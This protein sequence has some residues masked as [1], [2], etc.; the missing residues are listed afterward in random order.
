[1]PVD[2]VVLDTNVW[3]HLFGMKAR[4]T[5]DVARW[6]A[7]LTGKTVAIAAQTRAELLAW[8]LINNIGE[9]RASRIRVHLDL[10]ATIPVDE[11]VIQRFARLTADARRRG[12]ALGSKLHTADRW[13]AATAL[14]IDSPLL[15]ADGV[16][17]H[18]PDL[19]LLGRDGQ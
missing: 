5:G 12:D 15:T 1:M 11:P 19:V 9:A 3:S 4:A 8:P 16:F 2:V 18:D 13:I 7:L 6:R 14:A 10:T 17:G